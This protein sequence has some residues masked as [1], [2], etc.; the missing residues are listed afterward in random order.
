MPT[1]I[2]V[3][4]ATKRMLDVAKR[5]RQDPSYDALVAEL[6]RPL[7]SSPASEFG[8]CR[9]SRRFVRD[10]ERDDHDL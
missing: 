8:S 7:T 1:T 3:S 6:L 4:E 5:E 10:E 9:G 2:Q